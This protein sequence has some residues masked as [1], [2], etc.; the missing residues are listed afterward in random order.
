MPVAS[1]VESWDQAKWTFSQAK[2]VSHELIMISK[3][4]DLKKRDGRV[5]EGVEDVISSSRHRRRHADE[6]KE[7]KREEKPSC[8]SAA[9]L[10]YHRQPAS[11]HTTT[12]GYK[13]R[14]NCFT[15]A[16]RWTQI[17][18]KD[19]TWNGEQVKNP[20]SSHAFPALTPGSF[21]CSVGRQ[22]VKRVI[23]CH[24]GV[25]WTNRH[26]VL[27]HGNLIVLGCLPLSSTPTDKIP[28]AAGNKDQSVWF[29][30][31]VC[32]MCVSR[33]GNVLLRP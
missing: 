5:K 8:Q 11:A 24:H 14:H 22:K 10:L 30:T 12:A 6:T 7:D 20:V 15:R 27:V 9:I 17:H 2:V 16:E 29:C 31:R 13:S 21:H 19:L 18:T 25:Q 28:E 3:C 4:D 33:R 32:V 23:T 26:V 1:L